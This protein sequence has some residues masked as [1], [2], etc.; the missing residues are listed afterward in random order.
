M[1]NLSKYQCAISKKSS[2][3]D[4][5]SLYQPLSTIETKVITNITSCF[6]TQKVQVFFY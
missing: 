2:E 5:L 6:A 4:S 3:Y 1:R